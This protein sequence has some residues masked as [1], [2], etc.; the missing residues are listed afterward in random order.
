M[1]FRIRRRRR[2]YYTVYNSGYIYNIIYIINT[3]ASP[4]PTADKVARRVSSDTGHGLYNIIYNKWSRVWKFDHKILYAR[5]H[6][7]RLIINSPSSNSH[8]IIAVIRNNNNNN[9]IQVRGMMVRK[10]VIPHAYTV[11]NIII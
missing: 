1:I 8:F 6:Y 9:I 10:T 4:T 11:Y 3:C 5:R 7:Y 2:S